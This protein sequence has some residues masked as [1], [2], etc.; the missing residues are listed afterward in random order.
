MISKLYDVTGDALK[1]KRQSC[2]RC[3]DGVFL[4]EHS[5]RLSCGRCSYTQ[6]KSQKP[7]DS[8]NEASER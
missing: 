4:A 1:R 6:F 7:E 5:D 2:P 8:S 3:G